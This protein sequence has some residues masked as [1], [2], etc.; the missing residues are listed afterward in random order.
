M[1]APTCAGRK[2][3]KLRLRKVRSLRKQ[4]QLAA[5]GTGCSLQR[6]DAHPAW[7]CFSGGFNRRRRSTTGSTNARVFPLPVQASTATSLL[8]QNSGMV[9]SCGSLAVWR[10]QNNRQHG[11]KYEFHTIHALKYLHRGGLGKTGLLQCAQE[12]TAERR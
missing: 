6:L 9:A 4:A 12:S 10:I 3:T 11:A 8:P 1:T 7:L 5:Q 2:A